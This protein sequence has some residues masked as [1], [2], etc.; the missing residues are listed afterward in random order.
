[1]ATLNIFYD[2][3][4]DIIWQT[5]NECPESLILDQKSSNNLDHLTIEAEQAYDA[6]TYYING[7]GDDVLAYST[8]SPTYSATEV[9][10]DA[11]I[12]IT[13]VPSG[14]EVFLDNVSTGTMS[15]TTLTLTGIQAGLFNIK[16]KQ[17]HYITH[18]TWVKVKR[19]GE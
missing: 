17:T 10:L 15:N 13:G 3:N 6:N 9:V 16:L 4:K 5:F 18:E 12:N 8:F 19:R 14:T 1:M 7:D 11:V 2:T